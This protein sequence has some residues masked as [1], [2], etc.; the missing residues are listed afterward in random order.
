MCAGGFLG[1]AVTASERRWWT[2]A[3]REI[4]RLTVHI[5]RRAG[6]DGEIPERAV[7]GLPACEFEVGP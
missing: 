7:F 4:S 6:S 1:P 3:V 2:V 5:Q